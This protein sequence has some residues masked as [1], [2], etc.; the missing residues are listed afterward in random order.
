MD[1]ENPND[2]LNL[3]ASVAYN[4]KKF[5]KKQIEAGD[6]LIGA[7]FLEKNLINITK[8]PQD[9]LDI[10]SGLGTAN[11]ENLLI[12][13]LIYEEIVYGIIEIASLRKFL[14]YEIEFIE[15]VCRN[16]AISISTSE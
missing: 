13:P 11:P 7:C 3:V 14:E 12:V 5:F 16:L 4:R 1:C 8:L 15:T 2:R 10:T 9:Y 6:G